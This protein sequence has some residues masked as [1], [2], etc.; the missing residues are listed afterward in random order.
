MRD[1]DLERGVGSAEEVRYFR[2]QLALYVQLAQG[3]GP[4]V[5]ATLRLLVPFD[6]L[7]ALAGDES[8]MPQDRQLA[9]ELLTHLYVDSHELEPVGGSLL[10]KL[11]FWND[12][13]Y[14]Y[15]VDELRTKDEARL[16]DCDEMR[17]SVAQAEAEQRRAQGQSETR[18]QARLQP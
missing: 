13:L 18:W 11:A 10:R 8:L 15:V 12:P 1:V 14:D 6:L 9:C 7:L 3:N 17:G 5:E 2:S 4:T 16:P